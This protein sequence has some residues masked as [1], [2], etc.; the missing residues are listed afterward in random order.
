MHREDPQIMF[1]EAG[2]FVSVIQACLTGEIDGSRICAKS[3]SV[4]RSMLTATKDVRTPWDTGEHTWI[5]YLESGDAIDSLGKEISANTE[6]INTVP[7]AEWMNSLDLLTISSSSKL[8]I[9]FIYFQ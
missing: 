5:Y 2:V 9:L 3:S 4:S 8:H 7:S 6:N 1:D